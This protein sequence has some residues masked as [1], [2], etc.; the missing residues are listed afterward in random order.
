MIGLI[1]AC[2]YSMRATSP[3]LCR[4]VGLAAFLI[5][6]IIA[7]HDRETGRIPDSLNGALLVMGFLD[8][9]IVL[10][11]HSEKPGLSMLQGLRG[12]EAAGELDAGGFADRVCGFL[13]ISMVLFLV[14]WLCGKGIGGGDI[15]L[16][17]AAGFLCG[18]RKIT[19]ACLI[20]F[21]GAGIYGMV[22]LI[23]RKV[24]AKDHFPLGP[25]LCLGIGWMLGS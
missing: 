2:R 16:M 25:F 3:P 18:S 7:I 6:V 8:W 9:V 5:L 20:G 21:F 11:S 13:C 19:G 4:P 1:L 17:A 23:L 15:K 22:L 12:L 24:S 14:S 10:I